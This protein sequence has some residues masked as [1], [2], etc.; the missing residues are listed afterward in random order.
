MQYVISVPHVWLKKASKRIL[1]KSQKLC[2]V[3]LFELLG[4]GNEYKGD[5]TLRMIALNL[6]SMLAYRL[7]IFR[8][9]KHFL[10][11]LFKVIYIAERTNKTDNDDIKTK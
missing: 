6:D 8:P 11:G 5:M 10:H 7:I 3:L 4:I 9:L 2:V 1:Y